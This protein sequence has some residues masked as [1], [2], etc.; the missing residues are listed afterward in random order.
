LADGEANPPVLPEFSRQEQ[1]TLQELF[2]KGQK[3]GFKK[4]GE[5]RK[6][7]KGE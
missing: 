7:E 4:R 6:S 3:A 2:L 5:D 1:I